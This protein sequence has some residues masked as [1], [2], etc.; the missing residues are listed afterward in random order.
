M[1]EDLIIT[2]Q[3]EGREYTAQPLL[4]AGLPKFFHPMLDGSPNVYTQLSKR[5]EFYEMITGLFAKRRGRDFIAPL[6]TLYER[7]LSDKTGWVGRWPQEYTPPSGNLLSLT[8]QVLEQLPHWNDKPSPPLSESRKRVEA[9]GEHIAALRALRHPGFDDPWLHLDGLLYR[10]LE[11]H[12]DDRDKAVRL[13]LQ[14]QHVARGRGLVVSMDDLLQAWLDA[15]ENLLKTY[16]QKRPEAGDRE[17]HD[18]ICSLYRILDFLLEQP[19]FAV[20]SKIVS[21][22][23]GDYDR[24]H[25][26][27]IVDRAGYIKS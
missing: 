12:P 5:P 26:R 10:G 13:T 3:H 23:Y 20:I 6:Q 19:S 24:K 4:D 25:V 14:A 11:Q 17:A 8:L 27:Q 1:S 2:I 15:E 18:A 16:K 7:A 21:P 9:L 22:I